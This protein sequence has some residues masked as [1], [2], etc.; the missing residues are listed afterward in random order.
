[1]N[2]L[3]VGVDGSN[4]SRL[5]LRWAGPV[6]AATN[7]SLVALEAWHGGDPSIAEE[8]GRRVQRDLTR[9]ATAA[10]EGVTTPAAVSFEA[11]RGPD[12]E[13]ILQRVTP[14]SGLVLGSRGRGGFVGLLLGSVSRECIEHAP[15]PV[16]VVRQET[17]PPL[18]GTTILV[19][20]DGSPSARARSNGRWPWPH[21]PGPASS[22]PRCGRPGLQ[23]SAPAFTNG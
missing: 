3:V 12:V 2:E 8:T 5:A 19:G 9:T 7:I 1:M 22:P 17:P 10:L 6:A 20:H 13:A 11:R 23:R 18:A 21:P 15:C 14:D 16:M 4:E